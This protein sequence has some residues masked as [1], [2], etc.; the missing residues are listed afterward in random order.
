M[1]SRSR[2]CRLMVA[3]ASRSCEISLP[4]GADLSRRLATFHCDRAISSMGRM[5]AT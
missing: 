1:A 4:D 3:K 5:I 2:V